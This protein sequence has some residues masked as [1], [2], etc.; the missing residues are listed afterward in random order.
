MVKLTSPIVLP[1]QTEEERQYMLVVTALVRRLNLEST[2][3]ILGDTM[4]AL[5][6]GVAFWNPW[7]AAVP[8][9]PIQGRC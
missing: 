6:G 8:P 9:G 1:D 5:A 2:R 3:V 4:T 7:M